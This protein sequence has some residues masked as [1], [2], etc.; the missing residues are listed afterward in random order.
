[1]VSKLRTLSSK[2]KFSMIVLQSYDL[3]LQPF[4][5]LAKIPNK[6]FSSKVLPD[7][8]FAQVQLW[9]SGNFE[10]LQIFMHLFLYFSAKPAGEKELSEEKEVETSDETANKV[11]DEQTK[12]NDVS[13]EKDQQ[14]N[15]DED[16]EQGDL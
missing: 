12:D 16:E 7:H 1:M 8:R 6:K 3:F 10:V 14:E 11:E 13:D 2:P 9:V 4:I 15:E 5:F